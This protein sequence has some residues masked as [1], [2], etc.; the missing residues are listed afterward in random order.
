MRCTIIITI[1]NNGHTTIL[2]T[3][4][5]NYIHVIEMLI[6]YK[7]ELRQLITFI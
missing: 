4:K 6:A 2:Q 1:F 3:Y 7:N 5:L